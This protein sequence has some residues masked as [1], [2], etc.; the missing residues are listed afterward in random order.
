MESRHRKIP[1]SVLHILAVG[2]LTGNKDTEEKSFPRSEGVPGRASNSVPVVQSRLRYYGVDG[3]T[4][5]SIPVLRNRFLYY[6][7]ERGT[8]ESIPE[9][10]P[11]LRDGFGYYRVVYDMTEPVNGKRIR[12]A[13][14]SFG[15]M[16]KRNDNL[17]MSTKHK[18]GS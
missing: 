11:V 4:T 6:S 13:K 18:K 14:I 7:V 9:S 8:A 17:V 1:P 12:V 16:K 2:I 5:R 3:G 10:I 15:V